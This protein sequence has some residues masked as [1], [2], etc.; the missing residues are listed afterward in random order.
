MVLAGES[1]A[2]LQRSSPQ[3]RVYG[4]PERANSAAEVTQTPILALQLIILSIPFHGVVHSGND[5]G[6][7][8]VAGGL[9]Q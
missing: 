5:I 8:L 2:W 1:A 6:V 9:L 7:G 4:D 3:G